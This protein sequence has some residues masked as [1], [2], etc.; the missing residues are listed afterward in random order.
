MLPELNIGPFVGLPTYFLYLSLVF[1]LMIFIAWK[2]AFIRNYPQDHALNISMIMIAAGMIGGR[3]FHVFYEVPEYYAL[4]PLDAFKFWQGGFVFFGGFLTAVFAGWLYV[5]KYKESFLTWADFFA[6]LGALGYG[7][8]RL[9]CF[10]AGC[11]YGRFCELPWA[12]QGRH[13]VQLYT[14]GLEILIAIGLWRLSLFGLPRG[15]VFWTWVL[16]HSLNRLFMEQ[17]RDD[18]RGPAIGNFT[19]SG[20]IALVLLALAISQLFRL[21]L[22]RRSKT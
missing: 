9:A 10:I 19:V 21:Q 17:M 6:P 16:F 8:G 7:L 5:R 3:L 11:C 12:V 20:A 22:G 2:W 14:S 13:P 15:M 4:N 1:S 18:F